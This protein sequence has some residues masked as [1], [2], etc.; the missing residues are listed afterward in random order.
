MLG[1]KSDEYDE[2]AQL[3]PSISDAQMQTVRD[4]QLI[5]VKEYKLLLTYALC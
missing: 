5:E 2:W 1:H 4:T 3:N